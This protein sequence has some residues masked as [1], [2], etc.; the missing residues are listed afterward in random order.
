[1]THEIRLDPEHTQIHP[2]AF[3][4]Y[5]AVVVG[6]VHVAA[7]ASIWFGVV[8]RGD[9]EQIRIGARTNIQDNSVIHADAGFPCRIGAGVTVGHR[10]IVHG[11][12]VGDHVLVGMGATVMN[13]AVIGENSIIGANSLVTEGKV[14]PPRSLALGSPAKVVR[15]LTED[16]IAG[17]RLSATH[18][19]LNGQAYKAAGYDR[20]A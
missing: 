2:T 20:S 6:D 1:M 9:V 18:Y 13:G 16:E 12:Q 19:V 8:I 3:V 7:E 14:I 5:N 11:A 17:I 10:A 15:E 4:A